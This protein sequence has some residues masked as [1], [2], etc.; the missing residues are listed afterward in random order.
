[1]DAGVRIYMRGGIYTHAFILNPA[2]GV[3]VY[4]LHQ[5]HRLPLPFIP[6]PSSILVSYTHIS[7][8]ENGG[9]SIEDMLGRDTSLNAWRCGNEI[10]GLDRS[11]GRCCVMHSGEELGALVRAHVA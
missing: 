1:M 9:G 5:L 11:I 8:L 3:S 4:P 7:I 2:L 6:Y 10:T